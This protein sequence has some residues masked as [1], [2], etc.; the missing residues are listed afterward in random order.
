MLG[1]LSLSFV[2]AVGSSSTTLLPADGPSSSTC[3]SKVRFFVLNLEGRADR[4]RAFSAALPSCAKQAGACRIPGVNGKGLNASLPTSLISSDTWLRARAKTAAG[5]PS[6]GSNDLTVGSVGLY[7]AHALAWRQIVD[8]GIEMAVVA[9]DDTIFFSPSFETELEA[10]CST[11]GTWDFLQLQNDDNSWSKTAADLRGVAARPNGAASLHMRKSAYN[12]GF[13][14]LTNQ[15]A[16]RAL[17]LS[18]PMKRQLDAECGP[19]RA[20]LSSD[21]VGMFLPPIAQCSSRDSDAQVRPADLVLSTTEL[22]P[23]CQSMDL[24]AGHEG[25]AAAVDAVL[26]AHAAHGEGAAPAQSC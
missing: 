12:L 4:L 25:A 21:R 15:G 22:L 2:A 3:C 6:V 9:E 13:Y 7:V 20:G 16:R 23:D 11:N 26:A 5:I 8:E 18:F 14:A 10:L 1:A 19:L 24:F 17:G